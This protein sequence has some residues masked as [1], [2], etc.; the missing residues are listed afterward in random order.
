MM[1]AAD[2]FAAPEYPLQYW[3]PG[4]VTVSIRKSLRHTIASLF[5]SRP[6]RH[7]E[8]LLLKK[9]WICA[10]VMVPEFV[11]VA[12]LMMLPG[13]NPTREV[14][15]SP[16]CAGSAAVRATVGATEVAAEA[17]VAGTTVPI[18]RAEAA[19]KQVRRRVTFVVFRER[20]ARRDM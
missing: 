14:L 4:R 13:V 12:S 8:T 10:S 7:R 5:S 19:R 11:K 9:V 18:T 1:R 20:G 3:S 6:P 17:A 16:A 15:A 2:S